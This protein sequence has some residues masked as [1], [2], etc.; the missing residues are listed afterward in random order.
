VQ[1]TLQVS[2]IDLKIENDVKQAVFYWLI[3]NMEINIHVSYLLHETIL[4]VPCTQPL[5]TGDLNVAFS[6]TDF[7][8]GVLSGRTTDTLRRLDRS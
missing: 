5:L 6:F 4:N 2:I 1:A 3:S 8:A 7:V